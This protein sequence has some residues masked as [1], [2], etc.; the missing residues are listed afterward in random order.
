[1]AKEPLL[2]AE[3]N[4]NRG[5]PLSNGVLTEYP[6]A[7]PNSN[8]RLGWYCTYT[9][10]D[11]KRAA[12]FDSIYSQVAFIQA[13]V[14]NSKPREQVLNGRPRPPRTAVDVLF[15]VPL[16][17]SRPSVRSLPGPRHEQRRREAQYLQFNV[18]RQLHVQDYWIP[19]CSPWRIKI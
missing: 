18:A 14:A 3:S 9:G 17:R 19:Q 7:N 6:A 10:L 11:L 8:S 2:G 5:T 13:L 1:M 15:L 4:A 12:S 16:S